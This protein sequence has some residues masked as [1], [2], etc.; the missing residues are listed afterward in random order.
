[1]V[2]KPT[3]AHRRRYC[4]S[5]EKKEG[6]NDDFSS[7]RGST[8]RVTNCLSL[9]IAD[10]CGS[11]IPFD[12]TIPASPFQRQTVGPGFYVRQGLPSRLD[13]APP[14]R[15]IDLRMS[16]AE[17]ED[18]LWIILEWS[19]PGDDYD[20]GTGTSNSASFIGNHFT[21]YVLTHHPGFL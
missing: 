16:E 12:E 21:Y 18:P 3:I 5:N 10:C 20:R 11:R 15:I 6:K 9:L 2:H 17:D 4:C 7:D 13:V 14:S 19:A 8:T 1:M